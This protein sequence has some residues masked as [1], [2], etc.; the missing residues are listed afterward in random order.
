MGPSVEGMLMLCSNGSASLDKMAAI[1][2]HVYDKTLKNFFSST[3]KA[4][5]LNLGI[6][7]RELKV[8]QVCKNDKTRITFDRFM[9]WSNLCPNCCGNTGRMLHDICKYAGE[10][11]VAHGPLVFLSGQTARHQS[12][13]LFTAQLSVRSEENLNRY[14][15]SGATAK[16]L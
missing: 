6:Q 13:S 15:T 14:T 10:R 3:K 9:V 5:R 4:L 1:Y 2:I 12:L 11:I 7:H 16:M 8:Y